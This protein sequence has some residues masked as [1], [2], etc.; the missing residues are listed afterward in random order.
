[1]KKFLLLSFISLYLVSCR[2]NKIDSSYYKLNENIDFK[3]VRLIDGRKRTASNQTVY[4][5]NEDFRYKQAHIKIRN[6]HEEKQEF[7][8]SHLYLVDKYNRKHKV[9]RVMKNLQFQTNSSMI[10]TEKKLGGKKQ[11][12]YIV[13]FTPAFPKDELVLKIAIDTS[14]SEALSENARII[15]LVTE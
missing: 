13:D 1:M 4:T 12:L 14:D 6:N 7:D 8:L 3:I 11:G 15:S 2:I 10:N 9:S 5:A